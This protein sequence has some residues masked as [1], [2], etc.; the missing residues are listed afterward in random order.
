MQPQNVPS[1]PLADLMPD[2]PAR[3]IVLLGVLADSTLSWTV[4]KR[5]VI[6]AAVTAYG[7]PSSSNRSTVSESRAFGLGWG[8]SQGSSALEGWGGAGSAVSARNRASQSA[9]S[10]TTTTLQT[11]IPNLHIEV[12]RTEVI[13]RDSISVTPVSSIVATFTRPDDISG[14]VELRDTEYPEL[15][16]LFSSAEARAVGS[17]R[18]I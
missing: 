12:R 4:E 18:G 3:A 10:G 1:Q 6:P 17:K 7:H 5:D 13:P 2:L 8:A 11:D 9:N 16:E 15:R 14:R